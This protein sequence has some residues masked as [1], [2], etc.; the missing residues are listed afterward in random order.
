MPRHLLEY[1]VELEAILDLTDDTALDAL[2]LT[3]GEMSSADAEPC[4][5][6]GETAHHLGWEGILAPS[7]TGAGNIVAVFVERLL[8]RSRVEVRSTRVWEGPH[9]MGS[10]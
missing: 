9:D 1:E 5:R 4:Q 2:E 10:S 7:A 3:R 6:V 8:P